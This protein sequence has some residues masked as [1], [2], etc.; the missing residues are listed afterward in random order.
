MLDENIVEILKVEMD[1][2]ILSRM[3]LWFRTLRDNYQKRAC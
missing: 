1:E 3:P 2:E